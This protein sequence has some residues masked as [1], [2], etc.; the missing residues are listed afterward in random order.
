MTSGGNLGDK[1]PYYDLSQTEQLLHG[2]YRETLRD[3]FRSCV[4]SESLTGKV[5]AIRGLRI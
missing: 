3:T 1:V 4:L 2:R 5:N